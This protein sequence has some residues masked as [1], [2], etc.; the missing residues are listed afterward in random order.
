MGTDGK[1]RVSVTL[2]SLSGVCSGVPVWAPMSKPSHTS[3]AASSAVPSPENFRNLPERDELQEPV[4][5]EG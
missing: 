4:R 1:D 2:R 3:Q 5:W